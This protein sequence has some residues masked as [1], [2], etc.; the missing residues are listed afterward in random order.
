MAKVEDAREIV[1]NRVLAALDDGEREKF[2]E[3]GE[4]LKNVSDNLTRLLHIPG[5]T[6]I[7]QN[8]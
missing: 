7:V 5:F 3:L 4:M 8:T 2:T 6:S 1:R